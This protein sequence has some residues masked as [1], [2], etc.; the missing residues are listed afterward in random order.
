M[1]TTG[2]C[3][4]DPPTGVA[5]DIYTAWTSDP[6]AGL[7]P[8]AT[9]SGGPVRALI[10]AQLA[11]IAASIVAGGGGGGGGV[12]I[13]TTGPLTGGGAGP[14]YTLGLSYSLG[15]Q[16]VSGALTLLLH[17]GGGLTYAGGGGDE[18]A[19]AWGTSGTTSC[20][21]ND[22]RLSDARA[23]TGAA[24]GDLAG[25]YP[26]P[27]VA[28]LAITDA[29][30]ATANKDGA[31]GTA[32]MRTLGAGA[33]QAC[34]GNDA[35]LS[36]TRTPTAGSVVAASF[37]AGAFGTSS[38]TACVGN[39][40]RLSDARAPSTAGNAGGVM[41]YTAGAVWASTATGTAGFA[42]IS[43]GTGTPTWQTIQENT[44][45]R[46]RVLAMAN[47]TLSG[48]QTVDSVACVAGNVVW[49]NAQTT[50]TQNGPWIVAAGA[51]TR[52]LWYANG[53]TVLRGHV[54]R[55]LEGSIY[56]GASLRNNN[57]ADI[58]V[59]TDTPTLENDERTLL[60]ADNTTVIRA[61]RGGTAWKVLSL[62]ASGNTVIGDTTIAT[63]LIAK[64]GAG[65][66]F[67]IA[68]TTAGYAF[69]SSQHIWGTGTSF[70]ML[71][72]LRLDG[73][74]GILGQRENDT[75]GTPVDYV[76]RGAQ[77][78]TSTSNA[79]GSKI[80]IRGGASKGNSVSAGVTL[81]GSVATGTSSG[82]A[83]QAARDSFSAFGEYVQ[84]LGGLI[85]AVTDVADTNYV[86]KLTD[87]VI[88]YTSLT[89]TRTVTLLAPSAAIK[90]LRQTV[91]D[92]A[93]NATA[94]PIVIAPASG[95]IDG[96]ASV[97]VATNRGT[98]EVLC[99]GTG[100]EVLFT[101]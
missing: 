27:T 87:R 14:T 99:N 57:A 13:A 30:V 72:F 3:K 41:Y 60:M 94:A 89:A 92:S 59:G 100:W 17:T 97:S 21:G 64:A 62:D 73:A 8:A 37:G 1:P 80:T 26:N 82:G 34:A 81:G 84:L 101:K 40:S 69:T 75:G 76:L 39:D 36:D 65:F 28:L 10:G 6:D 24:G 96:A 47:L 9:V 52:P 63:T 25:T 77:A 61:I 91:R 16:V 56:G 19:V 23:P 33:A 98:Y 32:C 53:A 83:L 44:S 45:F 31:S 67:T 18:L 58:V 15:L 55:V 50:G 66:A 90:G 12:T 93:N 5:G 20:V 88:R 78:S 38:T 79:V 49:C 7:L 48:T 42:L 11:A 68:G 29:K 74:L 51:W 2:Q 4:I 46:A 35:R 54:V 22:T 85:D 95:T 70:S 43:N 71:P 86:A